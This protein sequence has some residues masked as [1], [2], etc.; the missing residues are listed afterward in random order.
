MP[1]PS[2]AA[3]PIS[4]TPAIARQGTDARACDRSSSAPTAHAGVAEAEA[5]AQASAIRTSPP[6]AASGISGERQQAGVC[7]APRTLRRPEPI[8][9]TD[10][11][12]PGQAERDPE[13]TQQRKPAEHDQARVAVQRRDRLRR[14]H[15]DGDDRARDG[16][17]EGERPRAT[18][19]RARSRGRSS[20]AKPASAVAFQIGSAIARS[21][22]GGGGSALIE[23][24]ASRDTGRGVSAAIRRCERS[25]SRWRARQSRGEPAC[26]RPWACPSCLGAVPDRPRSRASRASDVGIDVVGIV[27]HVEAA[28]RRVELDAQ[29]RA[30]E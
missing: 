20:W 19:R 21:A 26:G 1:M 16:D 22:A 30:A 13:Q 6:A 23:R 27:A 28:A 3:Q 12:E 25:W 29:H 5:D 18:S 4:S 11:A 24:T 15:E 10:E 8:R 17:R 7:Q 2:T 14:E 9:A